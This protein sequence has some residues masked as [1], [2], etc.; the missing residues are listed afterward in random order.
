MKPSAVSPD[1]TGHPR[2]PVVLVDGIDGSGKTTFAGRLAEAM[3]VEGDP[4]ALVHVDDFR[5]PVNWADPRGEAEVYWSSYFDLVALNEAVQE[6]AGSGA[7]VLL[8]GIFTL[9]LPGAGRC[10]LIY[11]ESDY[12]GAALRIF[13][14]DTALGRTDEDVR[15]R[16]EA[17]YFPAQRR[18]RAEY[19][20]LVRAS[21][22]VDSS[23]PATPRLMRSHWERLPGPVA[24]AA[25]RI[26]E[27]PPA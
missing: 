5:R 4:V 7:T 25:R 12:H 10:P 24:R 3:R 22:L 2:D 27:V 14:R 16:I 1:A 21:L 23:D 9:R 15:H 26:L 20:P 18:Y 17:R 19:D 8:E 13:A 11:L 6:V